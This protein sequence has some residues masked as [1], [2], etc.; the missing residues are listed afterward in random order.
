M[1][2]SLF[3]VF[4]YLNPFYIITFSSTIV[5]NTEKEIEELKAKIRIL[6][7][8]NS[9]LKQEMNFKS[10]KQTVIVPE[11]FQVLFAE[12]EKNVADY[13]SDVYNSAENGEIVI[14]GERYILIRSAALSFEFF[15]I[16]TELYKDKGNE[17]AIRIGNNF[18]FDIGHVLGKKD[19]RNFHERMHLTDP[20]QKLS[21]GPVHFAYTG[22]A[23]VE[24]LS[25]SSPTPDEN[26]FIKYYHHNS[27]EAQSW[28]KSGRRS[29][30][31]VCIM[32]SA[33]SSGWCEESFGIP[34]TAVEISC[35]ARGDEHCCFI[36]APPNRIDGYLE[37]SNHEV[38]SEKH[39]VPVFFQ[40]KI[41]EDQLKNSLVQKET[42]LKEVHHRV[43]NNLQIISS[44]F[45]L[46]MNAIQDAKMR[47]IFQTGLNRVNAMASIH[48]LIYSDADLASI[49]IENYFRRV[50]LAMAQVYEKP[51]QQV[52]IRFEFN[53]TEGN[54]NPDIAIPL[55][56]IINEVASNAFKHA[57][58]ENGILFLKLEEISSNYVL[59]ISD[60]GHGLP[61]SVGEGNLG[62]TL[63]SLL[64]EQIDAEIDRI[65]SPEGLIY[66]FEFKKS[67]SFS[68]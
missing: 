21:A 14:H 29:D 43:K 50:L 26:F 11:A 19:A 12:A 44:L 10:L 42:L 2:F 23:N 9:R 53:I 28:K 1:Y 66:R 63:I 25:E 38:S 56:L 33:Y 51:G 8:E 15:D 46:Q 30:H 31:P 64:A 58:T 47:D 32:N 20:V 3:F 49:D 16:I 52:E 24:I 5:M 22:W 40:R 6:E 55:G 54:F 60:N 41:V 36:M 13:F 48:E 65:S 57:F 59:T 7:Q 27:F 68:V 62:L 18:L 39:N 17:E 4:I 45:R 35:E 37:D 34:L 61:L 67:D